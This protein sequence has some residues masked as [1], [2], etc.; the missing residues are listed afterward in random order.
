MKAK[1]EKL[2]QISDVLTD[3]QLPD[4]KIGQKI[5]QQRELERDTKKGVAA[6]NK[7][8]KDFDEWLTRQETINNT[9]DGSGENIP[10]VN[11]ERVVTI[12]KDGK[13]V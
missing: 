10:Y 4:G 13:I 1:V 5:R 9:R 6:R 2:T 3:K 11:I 8:F 12:S 7:K